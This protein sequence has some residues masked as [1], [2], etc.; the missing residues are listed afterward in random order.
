M[1]LTY[2]DPML[3]DGVVRLRPWRDDDLDCVQ[4]AGRERRI[5]QF[6]SVP[7]EFTEE[8]GRAFVRRQWSRAT[9]GA[10]LSLA[11]AE[12]GTDVAVGSVTLMLRPQPA[13]AGLG[14][15]LVPAVRGRGLAV[16]AAALLT[17]W[18]LDGAGLARVEAW[19]EPDN[20]PSRRV[21]AA[22]GFIEEGR[23]RSFIALP[24]GRSD[25]VVY[26]RLPGDP[27]P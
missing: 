10:G 16:R 1:R 2:P 25:A 24:D 17:G 22:A 18:A 27:A 13:V 19:V 15:W 12:V 14:Y 7:P 5:V 6:T 9:E 3:T 20:L 21:L 23:L 8:A 26:S 4:Q 11:V